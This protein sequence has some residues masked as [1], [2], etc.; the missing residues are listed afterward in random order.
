MCGGGGK[1]QSIQVLRA[2]ACILVVLDHSELPQTY[3]LGQFG[4][5]LFFII[6][7]Y[8][9][10]LSTEKNAD[11]MLVKRLLRLAPC[12]YLVTILAIVVGLFMPS[13]M[14]H[15]NVDLFNIIKSFLF[16]SIKGSNN[17]ANPILGIGWTINLEIY[18][19]IIFWLA[20]K[21][22]HKY[23]ALIASVV[24]MIIVIIRKSGMPLVLFFHEYMIF[25]V[26]GM[27]FFYMH[28]FFAVNIKCRVILCV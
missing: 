21:I 14:S 15:S 19:Y 9:M 10:V 28:R 6:S 27:A 12:Y 26:I 7:G 13:V 1:I 17:L 3:N 11:K 4:V 16:L 8:V 20:T 24:L 22:S 2:L 5:C 23:R 25:F 18:F